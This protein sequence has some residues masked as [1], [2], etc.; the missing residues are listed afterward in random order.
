MNEIEIIRSQLAVE[1]SHAAEVANACAAVF[2]TVATTPLP[3]PATAPFREAG[4]SYLVWVLARFEERDQTLSELLAARASPADTA[5]AARTREIG[6]LL[7]SSGRSREALSRL[8]S[9]LAAGEPEAARARWR[10]FARFFNSAW[11]PRRAALEAALAAHASVADWRAVCAIDADSILDE[12]RRHARVL[13]ELPP[14]R[15]LRGATPPG[16]P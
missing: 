8:E 9:A 10:E 6:A 4:V 2:G 11:T 5:A 1:Q 16:T 14:G 15:E 7:A 12:R 13:A 3:D